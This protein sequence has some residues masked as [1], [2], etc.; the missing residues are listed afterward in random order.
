MIAQSGQA[1]NM[2]FGAQVSSFPFWLVAKKNLERVA[3]MAAR[4]T[5]ARRRDMLMY[6]PKTGVEKTVLQQVVG[7]SVEMVQIISQ[8][9]VADCRGA[10]AATHRGAEC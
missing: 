3:S 5:A 2:C 4:D 10:G 8:G 9:V 7:G 6:L 1:G